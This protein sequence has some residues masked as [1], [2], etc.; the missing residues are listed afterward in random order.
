MPLPL[1]NSLYCHINCIAFPLLENPYFNAQL[2]ESVQSL[3]N[4]TVQGHVLMQPKFDSKIKAKSLTILGAEAI[5][6]DISKN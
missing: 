2:S 3:M 4:S 5:Q 6:I 1:K